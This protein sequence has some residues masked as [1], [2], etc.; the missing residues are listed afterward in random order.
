MLYCLVV[1]IDWLVW[2]EMSFVWI[3][4]YGIDDENMT[5]IDRCYLLIGYSEK[6]LILLVFEWFWDWIFGG[7]LDEILL[8]EC[9]FWLSSIETLFYKGLRGFWS[10]MWWFLV[11]CK[12][13]KCL[14][15]LGLLEVVIEVFWG[16]WLENSNFEVGM[17]MEQIPWFSLTKTCFEM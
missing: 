14:I 3:F 9:D 1:W 6:V 8:I 4:W 2:W 7:L 17:W 5:S 12:W 10:G 11:W 15:L 16:I 13:V